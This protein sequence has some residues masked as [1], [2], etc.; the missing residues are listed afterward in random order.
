V[1]FKNFIIKLLYKKEFDIMEVGEKVEDFKLKS[2]D[3]QEYALSNFLG[4]KVLIYF[5]PKD[6]TP[7]CTIEAKCF[8]DKLNDLSALNVQVIGI[9]ADSVESHKKFKE[10]YQLNFP[11]LSDPDKKV[12]EYFNVIKEKNI[13]GKKILGISRESFLIDEEGKLIKHYSKVNPKEHTQE[14]I[15]DLKDEIEL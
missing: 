4:K 6:D 5:Y 2:D 7:G 10:K 14:I 12:A 11:L 3:G 9:S 13:F 1:I 15:D 8:R